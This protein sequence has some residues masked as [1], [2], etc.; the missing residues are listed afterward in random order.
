MTNLVFIP[1]K[2][3]F[4]NHLTIYDPAC[5]SGGM[6]TESQDFVTDPEGEIKA[7]VDVFLYSKEINHE[8][9]AMLRL[10]VLNLELGFN[11]RPIS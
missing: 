4:P 2:D 1:V 9:Y 10:P 6:Q 5:G 7:K 11:P 8:T 3:Q